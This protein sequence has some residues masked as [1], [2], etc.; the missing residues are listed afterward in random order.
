MSR[1]RAIVAAASSLTAE[2]GMSIAHLGG[3]A[4]DI[5]ISAAVAA[6]VAEIF[7]CSLAGAAFI[8]FRSPRGVL[9]VIEGSERIPW[10]IEAPDRSEIHHAELAWG[11][12]VRI[13]S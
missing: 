3:N 1:T 9:E 4:A 12:G 8:T 7:M 6:T 11:D 2:A 13:L 10:S 5:A